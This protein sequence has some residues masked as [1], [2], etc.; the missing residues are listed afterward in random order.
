MCVRDYSLR[1]DG[2]VVTEKRMYTYKMVQIAPNIQNLPRGFWGTTPDSS[3]LAA[4]Y[5][6][7]IVNE[8]AAQ[9]WEFHRV[10]SLGITENPGCFQF[11][12]PT[13]RHFYVITTSK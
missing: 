8:W 2:F 10:D 11:G 6:E 3:Q 7:K 13:T 9:G 4:A 1:L 5:L 12:V